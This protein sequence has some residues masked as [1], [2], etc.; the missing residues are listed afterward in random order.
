MWKCTLRCLK[1]GS[2]IPCCLWV[3]I[4]TLLIV[5]SIL[6][7]VAL[8]YKM[9]QFDARWCR[10]ICPFL[11]QWKMFSFPATLICLYTRQVRLFVL[12][13]ILLCCT[14]SAKVSFTMVDFRTTLDFLS[15]KK[16]WR[17]ACLSLAVASF[18]QRWKWVIVTRTE[19]NRA[20]H[21]KKAKLKA[22]FSVLSV[23]KQQS[24]KGFSNSEIPSWVL[25][26]SDVDWC[27]VIRSNAEQ[28]G[29]MQIY[30]EWSK[31]CKSFLKFKSLRYNWKRMS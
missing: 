26:Q 9:M 3:G 8:W 28:C 18:G 29:V 24:Y 12:Q 6:F 22:G 25:M 2:L 10:M 23:H 31:E 11:G 16:A 5:M 7:L 20:G 19:Q 30:A 4:F 27:G 21:N 17:F 13:I 14:F 15:E 1:F